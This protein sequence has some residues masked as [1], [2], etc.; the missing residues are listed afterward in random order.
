M[1]D[2]HYIFHDESLL[3]TSSYAGAYIQR[4]GSL[5]RPERNQFDDP[6]NPHHYYAQK[7][8]ETRVSVNPSSTGIQP[9]TD[10][11][12]S[13][14]I[15][16]EGQVLK[17]KIA[18]R[19]EA[20][21]LSLWQFYCYMITFWAPSPLLDLF[22]MPKKERQFAWRE[23]VALI[24]VILYCGVFVVYLTFGFTNSVCNT[25]QPRI[26][27]NE[28]GNEFLIIN[29][30][31]FNLLFSSHPA[32]AGIGAGT[33]ILYEPISAAG[34]VG[35]FLFQNVNGN[36]RGLIRPRQNCTIPHVGDDIAWYFPCKLISQ[37]GS[38]APDFS[39]NE[40]Y[41]GWGC[42][43]SLAARESYYEL[44]A[45]ADV[46][47]TW[48]DI[49]NSTRNLVVYNDEVLDLDL[50]NWIQVDD[51][52][53]PGAFD[54][55]KNGGLRGYDISVI[56]SN[57]HEK[58]LARCL[59]ELVKVGVID[60][61]TVGC[62]ASE[63]VLYISL[64]FI[65][66]VVAIKFLVSCYFH[67][68]VARKQGACPVDNKTL[69]KMVN[70]IE[71]WSENIN[72]QGPIREV[73]APLPGTYRNDGVPP[74]LRN[75]LSRSD[76]R[77]IAGYDET[78]VEKLKSFGVTTMTI[79]SVL[80]DCN[81]KPLYGPKTSTSSN[82]LHLNPFSDDLFSQRPVESLE[83]SILH[84]NM[85]PQPSPDYTP[86]GYPLIH[87]ICFV[88][89]YSEN[90][91]GLRTTLDSLATTTYP[92]SHK[93]LM[94]LCDGLIKGH[95][96][97]K[98]TPEIAL[99]MME[100]FVVPPDRVEAH[101]Y[102]AVAYGTKRH[103]MAK[104]YS[105]FYKYD[106]NT[107]PPEKQ[108]KVP[109]ICIVKCG[110]PDERLGPKPGNRGK[111]DSQVI[112]MSFLQ[113]V[114]FDE[115]M[116]RL[117]FEIL[118]NIWQTTGLMSEFYEYVLMVDADTKVFPDSL[119]HMVAELV[120]DPKV[121]GLCGETKIANKKQS[122]I[123]AIQVFEYY[124]SHHQAKAFESIF[125]SVTCLPGCF[126]IYR[127]KCPKGSEGF[128][129]PILCNPDIVERYSDN[130]TNNLHKKNL[131]L[132]GEDR[133]LSSLM[134]KTFP[135]RKQ[136]FVPKAACKTI[137][138]D[139]FG[140]LLSQRRRW[141]NSTVHNLMELVLINDLC[142][143]FCFSMQFVIVI[144]LIGTVVLPLAICL[145][146]YVLIFAIVAK[147]APVIT[148]ALLAVILGLP[149]VLI[150]V[151]ASRWSYLMWMALYLI[152]LP[153]WNFVLPTYSF[154]KFDDFSWGDTRQV[155]GGDKGNHYDGEG[156]FDGSQIQMKTWRE[157]E[158]IERMDRA[159]KIE[160]VD[161]IGES[162]S[163]GLGVMK[164]IK[165]YLNAPKVF[166]PIEEGYV[167]EGGKH[168]QGTSSNNSGTSGTGIVLQAIEQSVDD[169][170]DIF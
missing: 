146:I 24:S 34:K 17:P 50:L 134:L 78:M 115:R 32:A 90:E 61:D 140:V 10:I 73:T 28:V 82:V 161:E 68:C 27:N 165:Q 121:M 54:D 153:I 103:N 45:T 33:N 97:S 35:S 108:Q 157:Y 164:H 59:S 44:K 135:K 53:I 132:L 49:K 70:D 7:T 94:V 137:V 3:R 20:D 83:T 166:P 6:S 5:V 65:L 118:K 150:V 66:S 116:T 79:Q 2:E 76:L 77:G 128:W 85:I 100:E 29:G 88:T 9:N 19:R 91:E 41:S 104:V 71:D 117:E 113:K 96:N 160:S 130:V 138:P 57:S 25:E 123:T 120:K 127:I 142:G 95:G 112:L 139:Q 119:T 162:E 144:E 31:A 48:E 124:I 36:C 67:W 89:C 122:W 39:A 158:R 60:S 55:L 13:D 155:A 1:S 148:L 18:Q 14:I 125:G 87:G 154:W 129:V 42:H 136:I 92:N 52:E 86:F 62:I 11:F 107:V 4:T 163:G 47:F 167:Y 169:F 23:K 80:K 26:R 168:I 58:Q 99:D 21:P 72:T 152:A 145:T 156:D 110:T 106:N 81:E 12:P 22:G 46:Y 141:I 109:M 69:V 93:L 98:S 126:S 151:T 105:G 159:N 101:S 38:T 37:D 16:K 75:R 133:Y 63:V 143:T 170:D 30:K 102:V 131:L 111:R 149:G 56:L 8:K 15:S 74:Q 51:L 64:I 114:T 147:P 40:F 84:P 43:T